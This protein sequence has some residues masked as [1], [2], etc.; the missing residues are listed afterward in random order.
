MEYQNEVN[1][2]MAAEREYL[3][4][5]PIGTQAQADHGD[6]GATFKASMRATA[7]QKVGYH[8][9]EADKADRAA[10]FFRENPAFDDFIQLVRSGA[11]QF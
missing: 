5:S 6:R 7:E 8:R 11:I 3:R 1:A 9:S 2:K 4:K 10:A